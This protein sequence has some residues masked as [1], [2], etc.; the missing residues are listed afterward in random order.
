MIVDGL[1]AVGCPVISVIWGVHLGLQCNLR[2]DVLGN[3][4]YAFRPSSFVCPIV[5]VTALGIKKAV[6]GRRGV[7]SQGIAGEGYEMAKELELT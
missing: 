3:L 2:A 4:R 5:F 7:A 1:S 6:L